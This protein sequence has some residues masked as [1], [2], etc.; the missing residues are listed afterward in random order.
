VEAQVAAD[1]AVEARG[2]IKRFGADVLA[3]D[4]LDLR[5]EE[6]ETYGLLGPNGAGKTTTLQMLLGLVRPTSGL[7]RV[8]GR[9]PG[10]PAA[11]RQTG[12]M[13]GI[14]FYPF[15]SGRDNLRTVAR[16]AGVANSRVEVVLG[17]VGLAVRADDAV[18]GY[19]YG[20]TQR[21]GVAAALLKD[22]RLLILDEP[23]N[24]LDP[25]G[26]L[27]MRQL[28][29]QLS[30]EGRTIVLSS[31]DMDEVEQLCG[32]V[33]IISGGRLLAEGTPEHL[34]GAAHLLVRAEPVERAAALAAT[35]AGAERVGLSGGSLTLALPDLTPARAAAITRQLVGAG[36][37]VSEVRTARR[38]LRE[39]FLELTGRRTGG[40]DSVRRRAGRA[41][42]GRPGRRLRRPR[43]GQAGKGR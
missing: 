27:D 12:A 37:E 36:L 8:L 13:G 9:R 35:L 26:Q 21:L 32:R 15:L 43:A 4:G 10:D 6:G 24:G 42:A 25:A 23:S 31:H 3:L 2:V 40:S 33:G 41:E 11:L 30:G 18:A 14:A 19:S 28:M 16:R 38:P 29:R 17:L 20:M 5:I 7:I 39:V 1:L 22:P 34:R